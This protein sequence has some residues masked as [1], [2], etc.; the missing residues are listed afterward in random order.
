MELLKKLKNKVSL[1]KAL[2]STVAFAVVYSIIS[3]AIAKLFQTTGGAG[4]LDVEFEYSTEKAF[5]ILTLL[6][7]EGRQF[8][9][10]KIIPLDFLFIPIYMLFLFYWICY[11][12]QK[13]NSDKEFLNLLLMLPVLTVVFDVMENI[14]TIIMLKQYPSIN[15]VVCTIGSNMTLLKFAFFYMSFMAI[16]L[17]LVAS[18][19]LYF[20]NKQRL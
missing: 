19:V 17:L 12:L 9:I 1:K 16:I 13:I 2:L 20:K 8:Y 4:I 3:V 6:G 14:C 10:S 18:I 11:F 5:Q 15:A 7:A